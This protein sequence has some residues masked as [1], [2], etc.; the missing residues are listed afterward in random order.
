MASYIAI[1]EL[2]FGGIIASA[3]IKENSF[4]SAFDIGA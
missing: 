2:T 1:V 3:A 4:G